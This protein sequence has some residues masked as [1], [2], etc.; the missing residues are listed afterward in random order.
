[1]VCCIDLGAPESFYTEASNIC[2]DFVHSRHG[3]LWHNLA[4]LIG[5]HFAK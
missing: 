1:M 5:T 2:P 3:K 4:P